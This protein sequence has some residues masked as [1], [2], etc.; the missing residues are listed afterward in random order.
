MNKSNQE[1][2][3]APFTPT[4]KADFLSAVNSD[5]G[6]RCTRFAH[7]RYIQA[8]RLI[9]YQPLSFV[10]VSINSSDQQNHAALRVQTVVFPR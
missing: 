4:R 5:L 2:I 6:I 10:F 1:R 3:T 8:A 7:R 9:V